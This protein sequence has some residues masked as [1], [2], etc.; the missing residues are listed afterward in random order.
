MNGASIYQH[1][2]CL[3]TKLLLGHINVYIKN[4]INH[5]IERERESSLFKKE[6]NN[7]NIPK[8]RKNYV[9]GMICLQ[10][11]TNDINDS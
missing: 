6:N 3:I 1:I 7:F 4:C 9:K 11:T 10:R 8:L 2:N 5:Q